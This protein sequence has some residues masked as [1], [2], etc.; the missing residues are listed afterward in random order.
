MDSEAAGQTNAIRYTLIESSRR[1]KVDPWKTSSGFLKR[2]QSKRHSSNL[3][4]LP[5]LWLRENCGTG[6]ACEEIIEQVALLT[7]VKN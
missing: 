7:G 4:C 3:R 1:H 2:C 5:N 6:E